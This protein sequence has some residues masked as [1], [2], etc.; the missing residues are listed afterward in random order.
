M[1]QVMQILDLSL[2]LKMEEIEYVIIYVLM[3]ILVIL[4]L[5]NV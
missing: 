1:L 3:D 2:T 5:E 4:Q